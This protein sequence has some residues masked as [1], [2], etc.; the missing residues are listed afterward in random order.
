MNDGFMRPSYPDQIQYSYYQASLVCDLI[1]RD[2]GEKALLRCSPSTRRVAP[3][4]SVSEGHRRRHEGLRS[5][6]D[7]T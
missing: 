4:R 7:S 3:P 5:P 6:I 2:W 1:A